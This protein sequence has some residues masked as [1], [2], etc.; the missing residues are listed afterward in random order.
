MTVRGER[1]LERRIDTILHALQNA[2][3]TRPG[4]REELE[5]RFQGIDLR[6]Y[7]GVLRH[8]ASPRS[9]ARYLDAGH[10]VRFIQAAG[11]ERYITQFRFDR[12][13][14]PH[15]TSYTKRRIRSDLVGVDPGL[16][17]RPFRISYST[18]TPSRYD[19]CV[20]ADYLRI[21]LR[22]SF[23]F[24]AAAPEWRIDLSLVWE[25]EMRNGA[26]QEWQSVN[27]ELFGSVDLRQPHRV[28]R[29]LDTIERHKLASMKP[30]IEAELV[31][32]QARCL[33][34]PMIT[35]GSDQHLGG[36][37][38]FITRLVDDNCRGDAQYRRLMK[39]IAI[40]TGKAP[41]PAPTPRTVAPA[42][43]TLNWTRYKAL[44]PM[45]GYFFAE[46]S[47][48][49]RAFVCIKD[50]CGHVLTEKLEGSFSV[51]ASALS[52]Q[53]RFAGELRMATVVDGELLPDG[54]FQAIDVLLIEG[55]HLCHMGFENRLGYLA[56]AVRLLRETGIDAIAKR[57]V[58]Q[59][60]TDG[61]AVGK[62]V[63]DLLNDARR[64][65]RIDGLIFVQPGRSY[66]ETRTYKWKPASHQTIDF[67]VREVPE[68]LLEKIGRPERRGKTLH[69]LF[70]GVARHVDRCLRLPRCPGYAEYFGGDRSR[71]PYFAVPFCPSDNSRACYYW[72]PSEE[73][74]DGK[75]VELKADPERLCDPSG[76]V[77]WTFVRTRDDRS[78]EAASGAYIGNN[79]R[80]AEGAWRSYR[81]P[82]LLEHLYTGDK[83]EYF[84]ST[85]SARQA[86]Q[87]NLISRLKQRGLAGYVNGADW[88]VDLCSGRGQDL[89]RYFRAGVR[90]LVAVDRDEPALSELVRRKHEFAERGSR[91]T[92]TRVHILSADLRRDQREAIT[93]IREFA[94]FPETGCDALVC[95][96]AVHYF[97]DTAEMLQRFCG[98]CCAL[99]R[100]D[101][102]LV[103]TLL[104]GEALHDQFLR[105]RIGYQE[106]WDV[107]DN[108]M[109]KNSIIRL[110]RDD[111]LHPFGQEIA[112][113]Q[114]F[115][116]GQYYRE[117]L[118][119]TD[120]LIEVFRSRLLRLEKTFAIETTDRPP[121][122]FENGKSPADNSDIQYAG[123]YGV[124]VFKRQ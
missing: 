44:Y 41:G 87:T 37:A 63:A 6:A 50:C 40:L 69:F 51:D 57:F 93:R 8:L 110:Y 99:L 58:C 65:Y 96:L 19:S 71:Q 95:N 59:S 61:S 24:P 107:P 55:Q 35:G 47:D 78:V 74:I 85:K 31:G 28:L 68:G 118:V 84:R 4:A 5:L 91:F 114:P 119:N 45:H 105:R 42:V 89:G 92:G 1:G 14:L 36:V 123:L 27:R 26:R 46:K 11:D 90:N 34:R 21:L 80:I 103:L 100:P 111:V 10:L 43:R 52:Q 64:D 108:G 32:G 2:P 16:R 86:S 7:K 15:K 3:D 121:A 120:A 25:G 53:S 106:K 77:D 49:V 82:F 122:G 12:S 75:V 88:V 62:I 124:Y 70:V 22:L 9:G 48:G 30:E 66:S 54:R 29:W 102:Y 56:D 67:L 116:G 79:F 60:S 112:L 97:A 72:H 13:R 109:P 113:R 39:H 115:S 17:N 73:N 117:P 23:L 33:S 20:N 83:P 81:D 38:G 94:D 76:I 18:E 98:L 104:R 101:G